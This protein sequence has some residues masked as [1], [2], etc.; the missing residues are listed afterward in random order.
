MPIEGFSEKQGDTKFKTKRQ[1]DKAHIISRAYK[2]L[3]IGIRYVLESNVYN[4]FQPAANDNQG[5]LKIPNA[6]ETWRFHITKFVGTPLYG[7]T[8]AIFCCQLP[9]AGPS[10]E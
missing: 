8:A 5:V 4:A 2:S 10:R 1:S 9:S 6:L 7:T 3:T